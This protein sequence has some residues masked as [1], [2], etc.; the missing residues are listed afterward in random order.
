MRCLRCGYCCKEL[1]VVIVVDPE[2]GIREDNLRSINLKEERC[3]HLRGD[4]VGEYSCAIHHYSWY[5]ETPCYA[6]TQYER[7]H[8]D[9]RIGR[10]L[11][12]RQE[13]KV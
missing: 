3:P 1:F 9:C 11:V 6:H 7:E 10:H 13:E 4:R 2:R 8:S 12:N 5:K